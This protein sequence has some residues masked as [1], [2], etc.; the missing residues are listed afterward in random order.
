[1][2]HSELYA[3]IVTFFGLDKEPDV[4]ATNSTN[5]IRCV[6][7]VEIIVLFFEICYKECSLY[8]D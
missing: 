6:F 7:L 8:F 4:N 1:M 5:V 2:T 3:H